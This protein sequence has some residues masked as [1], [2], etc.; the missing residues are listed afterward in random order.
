MAARPGRT[1]VVE[2]PLQSFDPR[3][4]SPTHLGEAGPWS[5]DTVSLDG[6]R[7]L[8]RPRHQDRPF[9]E[10]P[11]PAPA[12]DVIQLESVVRFV[13]HPVRSFLRERLGIYAGRIEDGIADTLPIALDG[14]EKWEIADRLLSAR[15]IGASPTDALQA[16]RARGLLPPGALADKVID[17][18]APTIEA[19]LQAAK[20]LDGAGIESVSMEVNLTLP[21][22]RLLIGSVPGVREATDRALYV[23]LPRRQAP[24]GGMGA[25][26]GG[27]RVPTGSPCI[28]RHDRSGPET[29]R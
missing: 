3:N 21:D 20:T 18:L 1:V 28:G 23:F 8:T 7:A 16:E 12:A 9:L 11:L 14:L 29:S 17:E 27:H 13:E 5:F 10:A 2:H 4:F 25:V 19:I 15:L 6:A 22:G 26:P 24:A